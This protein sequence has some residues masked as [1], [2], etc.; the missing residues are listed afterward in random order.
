MSVPCVFLV[1]TN[2]R[3]ISAVRLRQ[4]D[5]KGFAVDVTVKQSGPCSKGHS[6]ALSVGYCVCYNGPQTEPLF[7]HITPPD[8][9]IH[10]PTPDTLHPGQLVALT[11]LQRRLLS[12]VRPLFTCHKRIKFTIVSGPQPILDS[13]CCL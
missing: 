5:I 4:L 9:G 2:E 7:G 3:D 6:P 12:A 13:P 8:S 10:F 1:A 11:R